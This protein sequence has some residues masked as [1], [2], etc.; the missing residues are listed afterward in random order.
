[1]CSYNFAA[2]ITLLMIQKNKFINLRGN[3]VQ[4]NS[5]RV[6]MTTFI[7]IR[8]DEMTEFLHAGGEIVLYFLETGVFEDYD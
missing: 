4:L 8:F 7:S 1:M 6:S 5:S 3:L 2:K